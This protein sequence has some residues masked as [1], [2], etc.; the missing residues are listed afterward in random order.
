MQNLFIFDEKWETS[1]SAGNTHLVSTNK[2]LLKSGVRIV[3]TG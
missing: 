3:L 1:T 2:L